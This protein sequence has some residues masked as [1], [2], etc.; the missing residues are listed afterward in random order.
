[1]IRRG[2]QK[3]AWMICAILAVAFTAYPAS[4]FAQSTRMVRIGSVLVPTA[5]IFIVGAAIIGIFIAVII[6]LRQRPKRSK[7]R[8]DW[9]FTCPRCNTHN[10]SEIPIQCRNCGN[11][12]IKADYFTTPHGSTKASFGCTECE[13]YHGS[14]KCSSCGAD[15]AN[16]MMIQ[17]KLSWFRPD[18][19]S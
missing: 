18:F 9:K 19:H 3:T 14:P 7:Y 11:G 16:R 6:A 15:A 13:Q 5:Y 12:V 17:G 2:T 8:S 4:A 10:S 1:M